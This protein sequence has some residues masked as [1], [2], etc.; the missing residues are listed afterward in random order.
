MPSGTALYRSTWKINYWERQQ[1]LVVKSKDPALAPRWKLFR[2]SGCCQTCFKPMC[3]E[4]NLHLFPFRFAPIA[5]WPSVAWFET[6]SVLSDNWYP[7]DIV[8]DRITPTTYRPEYYDWRHTI[9][10]PS[11][12][13]LNLQAGTVEIVDCIE[14]FVLWCSIRGNEKNQ[15][16]FFLIAGRPSPYSF[17][18]NLT[19]TVFSASLLF[20]E[21]RAIL[22]CQVTLVN[23][24]AE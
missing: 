8:T 23:P 20:D 15:A 17:M 24:W 21:L 6:N 11:I 4:Y 12:E 9:K 5:N 22:R 10:L 7:L 18:K 2:Q 14:R 3:F 1:W 13:L 19:F 16:A